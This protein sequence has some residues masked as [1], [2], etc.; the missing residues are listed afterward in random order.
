MKKIKFV[1]LM[2]IF[3]VFLLST[4]VFASEI[5][6]GKLITDINYYEI[7]ESCSNKLRNYENEKRYNATYAA[8]YSDSEI[9][10]KIINDSSKNV[11]KNTITD[12]TTG[13]KMKEFDISKY[14]I[15]ISEIDSLLLKIYENPKLFYCSNIGY[16]YNLNNIVTHVVIYYYLNQSQ[17]DAD[18]SIINEVNEQ[19]LDNCDST[20]SAL[21]KVIYT[22]DFVNKITNYNY[23]VEE[24]EQG[25]S[26][27]AKISWRS[28]R[29]NGVLVDRL[30]VCDG[31]SRTIKY[32]LDLLNIK[33]TLVTS[34]EM[35]HAWNLVNL[36]NNYYHIDVTWNDLNSTGRTSYLYF[37]L[38]D[39]EIQNRGRKHYNYCASNTA[40]DIKYDSTQIWNKAVSYLNYH[41]DYWYYLNLFNE[42]NNINSY[43]SEIIL[44]KVDINNNKY[45]FNKRITDSI[46][47]NKIT[48]S[49]CLITDGKWLYF[50][51]Y[52]KIYKMD[53]S[54]QNVSEFYN[55]KLTDKIF[56]LKFFDY[57]F[58][59]DTVKIENFNFEEHSYMIVQ[60]ILFNKKN[61]NINYS[62][63]TTSLKVKVYPKELQSEKI[64]WSS[65][66]E[67]V[68]KVDSV[69]KLTGLT[70]G[71]AT[72]TAKCNGCVTKCSVKVIDDR[73]LSFE[74][75]K[76]E[77][78][79]YNAVRYTY[80]NK[81]ISGYNSTT[82]APNDKLTRGM[83]VT[84]LY[85]ME[86]SPNNNGKS[87]FSDVPSTE[88]YSKAIKWAVDNH[89]V[90]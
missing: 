33:S 16:R 59:Y 77:D 26:D 79:F 54:G 65:S 61:L 78:W 52:D 50:N 17:I 84:I 1:L 40:S 38:S 31:Y 66:N 15:P 28:H 19:F 64:I 89:I 14:N 46:L 5:N 3:I 90:H 85:R 75:V 68:V 44:N 8:S 37:L 57:K 7:K 69:G 2:N 62:N 32:F 60:K 86:N 49:P 27:P 23:E 43:T 39:N 72:I 88:W 29:I 13:F 18:L 80:F 11:D 21:E 6:S 51:G 56:S 81:M 25:V 24:K 67:K 20:W 30:A 42:T 70:E 12:S 22:H 36:N 47:K 9:I 58:Y 87:K 34:D 48:F 41:E 82:F 55:P 45:I 74:D 53:F 71:S 73:V 83:I 63:P 35:N 10:N 76:K 4:K